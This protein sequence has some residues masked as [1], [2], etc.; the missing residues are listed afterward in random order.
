[1][2]V[3]LKNKGKIFIGVLLL[4]SYVTY[5]IIISNNLSEAY[6]GFSNEWFFK[7]YIKYSK[8]FCC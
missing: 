6:I 5:K 2:K 3:L 4:A 7:N 1:M 8:R